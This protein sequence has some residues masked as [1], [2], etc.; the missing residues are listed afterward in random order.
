[1]SLLS[2]WQFWFRRSDA[3]LPPTDRCVISR[4][5]TGL[6]DRIVCLGAAWLFA[7]NT[8]RTLIADWRHSLYSTRREENLFSRCFESLPALAGVPFV[9][10]D[11]VA[12]LRASRPRYPEC[13]NDDRLLAAAAIRTTADLF[14]ERDAAVSLIRSGGD[15]AAATV[16]FDACVNDGL[17]SV[18]DS[19]TF[20]GSL[21]PLP[22]LS[23]RVEA[24]RRDHL[25][26]RPIIGLHVRHG[27]GGPTGHAAFWQSLPA[28]I[29]RCRRAIDVARTRLAHDARVLLC[30]DSVAVETAICASIAGVICRPKTF[31]RAG[32]GELHLWQNAA[33]GR[34]DALVEMLL[35]AECDAL[36]RYPP[37]SFFS[38]YAAVMGRWSRS[39]ET[40]YDLQRPCEG[41]DPFSPAILT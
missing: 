26:R 36:I 2:R 37:G 3:E 19:R 24:F 16:V 40:V 20:L 13:W 33:S 32:A 7:R 28:A 41:A 30:T 38:F 35:L 17:V 18:D 15:V 10:D 22:A 31:R 5:P 11:R 8:G 9:G 39:A 21:R 14:E 34:D 4:R 25:D 6:G 23:E 27:N 12:R 1:L 29:E